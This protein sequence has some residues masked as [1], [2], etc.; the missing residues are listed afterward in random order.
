MKKA[1]FAITVCLFLLTSINESK[2]SVL[3]NFDGF[4]LGARGG[5]NILNTDLA[6]YLDPGP[7][8]A[9]YFR[10]FLPDGIYGGVSL[11]YHTFGEYDGEK[12]GLKETLSYSDITLAATAGLYFLNPSES[13]SPFIEGSR[14]YSFYNQKYTMGNS[15][16]REAYAQMLYLAPGAG[17]SF[18]LTPNIL[19]AG[20]ISYTITVTP[21]DITEDLKGTPGTHDG[22]ITDYQFIS[23]VAGIEFIF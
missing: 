22:G 1:L 7:Q 3:G 17:V 5:M 15:Y 6:D 2:A 4:A 10:K 20:K 23:I 16:S 12:N 13:V 18:P 9:I 11:I 19:I 14:G 21:G 8:G